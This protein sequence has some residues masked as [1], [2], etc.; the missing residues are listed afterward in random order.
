M[1]D[2]LLLYDGS[3]KSK[4]GLFISA[5]FAAAFGSRLSILSLNT[6]GI[7]LSK[8]VEEAKRYLDKHNLA[9]R[10]IVEEGKNLADRVN[11]LVSELNISTVICG[12]Y[13]GTGLLD[14][15]IGTDVDEIL[16]E[17]DVPVLICQ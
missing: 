6:P 14:R 8:P 1:D 16:N 13:T 9:Y 10:Y 3:L 2:L 7:N 5:Y 12:G 17:V 15:I 4:E 11:S